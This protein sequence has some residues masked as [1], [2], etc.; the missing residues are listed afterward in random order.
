MGEEDEVEAAIL[1]QADGEEGGNGNVVTEILEAMIM[2]IEN[3]HE[4]GETQRRAKWDSSLNL[5]T[6]AS[7]YFESAM[8][9]DFVN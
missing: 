1:V 6:A 8:A 7:V 5:D 4:L 3:D 9:L 2:R